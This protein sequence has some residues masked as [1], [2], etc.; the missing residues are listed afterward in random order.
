MR[1]TGIC[2]KAVKQRGQKR[3]I[4]GLEERKESA[5]EKEEK[6]YGTRIQKVGT[7]EY[8]S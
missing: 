7:I 2:S 4:K 5:Y 8:P 3:R 6:T 1:H